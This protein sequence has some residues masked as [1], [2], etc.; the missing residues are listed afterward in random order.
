MR[1]AHSCLLCPFCPIF[2]L[3]IDQRQREPPHP[4][5]CRHGESLARGCSGYDAPI[6][7]NYGFNTYCQGR[8]TIGVTQT[9]LNASAFGVI[10]RGAPLRVKLASNQ[11]ESIAR[12]TLMS[13]GNLAAIG[14]GSGA[15][16]EIF[17][18]ERTKL[19]APDTY[20]LSQRLR[21]QYGTDGLVPAA[22]P[23]GSVFVLLNGVPNQI[24]LRSNATCNAISGLDPRTVDMMIRLMSTWSRLLKAQVCD[25]IH[26]RIWPRFPMAPML[27]FPG[28]GARAVTGM[29]GDGAMC[30]LAKRVSS[31]LSKSS[32]AVT[33]NVNFLVQK[34]NIVTCKPTSFQTMSQGFTKC[35]LRKSLN[36]LGPGSLRRTSWGADEYP[37]NFG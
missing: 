4:T 30:P 31:I 18:F 22:W 36:G 29:I 13:G 20:E 17:Q 23:V 16:W 24:D 19:V 33:S 9:P 7:A 1:R 26:L 32:L 11:L 21:G 8:S 37:Y 12:E 27:I 15:N 28:Y 34:R 14:D 6:D 35:V 2:G 5:Y 3:A 25:P 10:D